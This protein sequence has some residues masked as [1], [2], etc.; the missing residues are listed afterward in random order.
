MFLSI[1]VLFALVLSI[2]FFVVSS[3]DKKMHEIK[4]KSF[5][6]KYYEVTGGKQLI[7]YS[8]KKGN[9]GF[10]STGAHI[11]NENGVLEELSFNQNEGIIGEDK[12]YVLE[13][14]KKGSKIKIKDVKYDYNFEGSFDK[15]TIK[16]G[17]GN[18]TGEITYQNFPNSCFENKNCIF[19]NTSY[20][21]E[22]N[23]LDYENC[24]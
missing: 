9:G 8:N 12:Y 14:L 5:E 2:L 3:K 10:I 16:I 15:Y 23:L 7:L 1:I 24:N 18:I 11:T 21:K 17:C 6:G 4:T 19:T 13:I 20:L 22:I